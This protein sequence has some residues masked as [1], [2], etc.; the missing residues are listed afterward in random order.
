M[1]K[2]GIENSS[3]DEE[4]TTRVCRV[5]DGKLFLGKTEVELY[6]PQPEAEKLI[7]DTLFYSTPQNLKTLE[8]MLQD[9]LL[10]MISF[11]MRLNF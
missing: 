7:P 1:S 3:N 6:R 4:Q 5:Q 10:G 2:L 11:M 9:F 8:K